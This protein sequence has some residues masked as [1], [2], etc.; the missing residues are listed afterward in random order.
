MKVGFIINSR[1]PELASLRKGMRPHAFLT[2]WDDA[3]SPMSFMR[4]RWIAEALAGDCQYE[5]YRPFR[6]YDAVV[7]LKS[8]GPHCVALAERLRQ[9]GTKVLFEANVD[10][11]TPFEG[12][13]RFDAM[14]PTPAQRADAIAITTLAD[15]VIAS[16]RHLAGVC[17][18]FNSRATWVPDN[19]NLKLRPTAVQ[20]EPFRAGRLQ[21]WWSGMAAKLFEFL[22]VEQALTAFADRIELQLVTDDIDR[23]KSR[24]PTHVRARVE[25]LLGRIPHAIHRFRGIPD[26]LKLYSGGGVIVSPRFLDVPY[27]LSHTEW[28][29]TLGMACDLPAIASPVPSYLDAAQHSTADALTIC[30]SD[31][32]WQ[33]ALDRCLS[34]GG[35][36]RE[37][38]RNAF[39]TVRTHYETGVVARQHS[40][41]VRRTCEG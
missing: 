29:I 33:H 6:S 8:M 13:A 14:V 27:N 28:K 2:G 7:F 16:S 36:L 32:D 38:G 15:S 10:Y 23:A 5:L 21:I 11:Y 19:V 26:L 20:R 35:N 34:D 22:A 18:A 30:H 9:K 24:W 4:F 1:V 25:G 31:E 17:A 39:E 3:E 40:A 41:W 12:E 37:A